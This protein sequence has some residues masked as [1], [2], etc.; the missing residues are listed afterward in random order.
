MI[1][2]QRRG[3][4][5]SR[6]ESPTMRFY[7]KIFS[8]K[9]E[10]SIR[11][12]VITLLAMLWASATLILVGAS[13]VVPL[14]TAPF[15]IAGHVVA[16]RAINRRIP[17]MPVVIALII[18]VVGVSM[19][20]ELVMA[21]RGE[22]IPVAHFLLISGA[23]SVFEARTRAGL[24]TQLFFSAL[25]MFFASELAFGN[26][27]TLLLGGYLALI[28]TFLA[29][30]QYTDITREASIKRSGGPVAA[31]GFWAG[32]AA[33]VGISAFVAFMLL[34]WDSSQTP[35]AAR[36]AILP[37]GGGVEGQAPPMTPEEA[38]KLL[39]QAAIRQ[40]GS[41]GQ[42]SFGGRAGLA[43]GMGADD[44][45]NDA[46]S[47]NGV[48]ASGVDGAY[49]RPSG[50]ALV[51]PEL[52]PGTVAFIRSGVAS[53]WRGN[54]YDTFSPPRADGEG[55]WIST[56]PDRR[57]IGSLFGRPDD[58]NSDNRYLQT[59]F[60]QQGLGSTFISGY[61]PLSI[62]IGRDEYGMPIAPGGSTY[63][64]VSGRPGIT[65]EE[66][67]MD[68]GGWKGTEY[69]ALPPGYEDIYALA[70]A[71][72]A[73]AETDFDRA[74][75]IAAYLN[76]LEYDPES[77]S[78]LE[79]SGDLTEF[80]FGERP[81]SAIDFATA[82]SLMSRAVG[83]QS[84][85]A[86]GFLP[87]VFN[88][89][90]GA[91]EISA[92]DLHAWAEVNF[93]QAGWVPF[94]ASSRPDLPTPS[95]LET[96]P[97][98]GLSSMLER[99]FGDDLAAALSS[100]PGGLKSLFEWLLKSGPAFAATV[101]LFTALVGFGYW[102]WLR[103]R[104]RV[105]AADEALWM[106][107]SALSGPDRAERLRILKSFSKLEGRITKAGFRRRRDNE[108]ISIYAQRA[109]RYMTSGGEGIIT[110]A[111]AAEHAAYAPGQITPE[112]AREAVRTMSGLRLQSALR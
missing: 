1:A 102:W 6:Q 71:M 13:L 60:M 86:T 35:E 94:D 36:F 48:G 8:D 72:T 43:N 104:R 55:E 65:P 53:Y 16:Y 52:E 49:Q 78:P 63:Q 97:P 93:E 79:S 33:F 109:A 68:V 26:E 22:R 24:Y 67:R 41:G 46:V 77:T 12:R 4:W 73:D 50:T 11:V 110:A 29:V 34:P 37:V 10:L 108:P 51:A 74:A 107:Y 9:P 99:R 103:M 59:F 38:R 66:L 80:V 96:P 56:L 69:S 82:Q 100:S 20:H 105:S 91:S 70:R 61:E 14:V 76:T 21:V 111:T 62:A 5:E 84:R 17:A 106:E 44:F 19:R 112:S 32:V 42:G 23:A 15:F 101:M 2:A 98:S 75:T 90:S 18:I 87:G 7:R 85:V 95:D 40:P 88:P 3:M 39:E 57:R 28:V 54:V 92:S 89:Y 30:S 83:L 64:V 58:E 45:G 47:G 27:F 31:T 81:G 25:I